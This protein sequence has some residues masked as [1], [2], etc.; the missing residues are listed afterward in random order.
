MKIELIFILITLF[1]CAAFMV[2]FLLKRKQVPKY[3]WK[4]SAETS[5]P[6]TNPDVRITMQHR[7]DERRFEEF[8]DQRL[9]FAEEYCSEIYI[10][11]LEFMDTDRHR[12]W[13]SKIDE[14]TYNKYVEQYK[15]YL[16]TPR[17]TAMWVLNLDQFMF[18][19]QNP[20]LC[21]GKFTGYQPYG[22]M[23]AYCVHDAA[24]AK[25]L[26]NG[27]ELLQKEYEEKCLAVYNPLVNL[28]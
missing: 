14:L 23:K 25:Y 12:D 21:N 28:A 15:H 3:T 7:E 27:Q 9:K 18:K 5:I 2:G 10:K 17:H 8:K 19:Q 1:S 13:R 4:G 11:T 26:K 22:P 6:W 20:S 16:N 24:T